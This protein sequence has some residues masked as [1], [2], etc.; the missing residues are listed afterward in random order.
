MRTALAAIVLLAGTSA[1]AEVRTEAAAYRHGDVALEG[2]LAYD[3]AVAGRRPGALVVHEWWGLNEYAKQR[4]R[5][6]AVTWRWP[7]TCTETTG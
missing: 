2:Y 3:D 7:S 4:A 1:L 5:M 6:L